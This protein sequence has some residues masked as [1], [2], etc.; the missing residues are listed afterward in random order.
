MYG[1]VDDTIARIRSEM[2]QDDWD[3]WGIREGETDEEHSL[4]CHNQLWG[5]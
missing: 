5:S 3:R 1:T 2:T 4:R